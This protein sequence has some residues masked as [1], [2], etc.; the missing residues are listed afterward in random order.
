M[1]TFRSSTLILRTSL[2]ALT[3]VAAASVALAGSITYTTTV[4][5]QT[6]ELQNVVPTPAVP[7]FNGVN[8]TSVTITY[9]GGENSSFTLHNHAAVTE[10]FHFTEGLDFF[11]DS[12]NAGIDALVN[13]FAPAVTN[14][15]NLSITETPG[16]TNAY[17][18]FSN[19]TSLVSATYSSPGD[20]SLFEG[21][22]NLANFLVTTQT[23]S[24]FLG[25]GGNIDFTSNTTADATITV[26]YNYSGAPPPAVPE[27]GTLGLF[28]TGLLGLAGLLRHKFM[29]S[30]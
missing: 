17:G 27:P 12:S 9:Q 26:T 4:P 21:A 8:L 20:L 2:V 30:R 24:S 15:N 18:P 25:G 22:G 23:L 7:L 14:I 3:L 11:L 29:K 6:T 13:G 1:K 5:M 19:P 10:I 16:Q 28:G